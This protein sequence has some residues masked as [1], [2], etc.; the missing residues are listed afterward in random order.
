ML[1]V[2]AL[3]A[4][5]LVG[6]APARGQTPDKPNPVYIQQGTASDGAIVSCD[7][8]STELL[9][10]PT[11]ST[12]SGGWR[13]VTCYNDGSNKVYVCPHRCSGCVSGT[14]GYVVLGAGTSFT[15]GGA[16]RALQLSC[17][18]SGGTSTVRCFAER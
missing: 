6:A 14:Y 18:A 15:F 10:C 12:A 3:A 4:A 7:T 13:A 16:A 8:S 11:A 9:N 2:F 1:R 5:L 17:I